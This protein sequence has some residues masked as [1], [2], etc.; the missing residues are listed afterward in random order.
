[1]EEFSVSRSR[2]AV[3]KRMIQLG[4]IANRSEILPSKRRKSRLGKEAENTE[5]DQSDESDGSDV[6]ESRNVKITV[7]NVRKKPK[8]ATA[9]PVQAKLKKTK[10]MLNVNE[11]KQIIDMIDDKTKENFEWLRESLNDAA[12]DATT[13]DDI[14]EHEDG[15]PLVPFTVAQRDALSN[16]E[17]KQLLRALGLQEP[18]KQMASSISLIILPIILMLVS[19]RKP[20]GESRPI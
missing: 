15:V 4:L 17:F 7:K 12:E 20:S 2:N 18:I 14:D 19:F 3:I 8:A 16:N 6:P 10:V 1:M 5:S 13:E 11:V 9:L